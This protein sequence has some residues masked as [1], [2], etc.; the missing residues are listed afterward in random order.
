G[1]VLNAGGELL[2][3]AAYKADDLPPHVRFLDGRPLEQE[4][5]DLRLLLDRREISL[6]GRAGACAQ[7]PS[8]Q[9]RGAQPLEQELD[10]TVRKC[11]VEPALV[12][13]VPV[14]DRLGDAC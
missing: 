7:A 12:A 8:C 3:E 9:Q 13:E 2:A 11:A 6:H 4:P 10:V 1:L 5:I 14:E